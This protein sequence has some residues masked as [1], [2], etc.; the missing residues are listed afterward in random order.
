MHGCNL[1]PTYQLLHVPTMRFM[2]NLYC[3][4]QTGVPSN[5]NELLSKNPDI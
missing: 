5:K 1:K 2:F 3:Y 4:K